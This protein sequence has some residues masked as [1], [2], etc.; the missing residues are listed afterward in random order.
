[1]ELQ[2]NTTSPYQGKC[3]LGNKYKYICNDTTTEIPL[4]YRRWKDTAAIRG[5]RVLVL[6]IRWAKTNFDAN[7]E[8]DSYFNYDEEQM[9]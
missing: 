3:S 2:T 5:F 1:M 6:R 8:S 4:Y 7:L 9:M